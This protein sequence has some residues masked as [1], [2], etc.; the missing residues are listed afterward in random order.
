MDALATSPPYVQIR[1]LETRIV[2]TSMQSSVRSRRSSGR[3]SHE[4]GDPWPER[5]F[6]TAAAISL[7]QIESIS[8]Q[9]E[10]LTPQLQFEQRRAFNRLCV[11]WGSLPTWSKNSGGRFHRTDRGRSAFPP[12]SPRRRPMFRVGT[13]GGRSAEQIRLP[14]PSCIPSIAIAGTLGYSARSCQDPLQPGV[15]RER[16]TFLPMEHLELR[17]MRNNV[18]LQDSPS[19]LLTTYQNAVLLA[20]AEVENGLAQFLRAQAASRSPRPRRGPHAERGGR[21]S[22]GPGNCGGR[23]RIRSRLSPKPK[24]S[25]KVSSPSHGEIAYGL[26]QVYRA[27]GGGWEIPSMPS[28]AMLSGPSLP[29]PSPA[30][31]CQRPRG[32][33]LPLPNLAFAPGWIAPFA[34]AMT[35]L[36]IDI[37]VCWRS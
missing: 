17:H 24:S 15:S 5:R 25:S 33:F 3:H 22:R 11:L 20:N 9:T 23:T 16:W 19:Q 29:E 37:L 26:I 14:K 6:R 34:S 31:C 13:A 12:D 8:A 30:E 27:L 28:A 2:C 4:L 21:R 10:A 18:R 1:T 32:R 7:E 35:T 36:I